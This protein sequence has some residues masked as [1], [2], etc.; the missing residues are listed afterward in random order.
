MGRGYWC[1]LQHTPPTIAST[2]ESAEYPH[3]PNLAYTMLEELEFY[4]VT[5]EAR[6]PLNRTASNS[7]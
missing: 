4:K 6:R 7:D 1:A 3:A 5:K 2:A